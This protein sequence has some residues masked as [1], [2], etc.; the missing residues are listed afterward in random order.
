MK[1][2]G[3]YTQPI[4]DPLTETVRYD[5]Y[6]NWLLIGS[7]EDDATATYNLHKALEESGNGTRSS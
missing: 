7:Y 4:Y 6:V 2:G 3:N 1:P 5:V